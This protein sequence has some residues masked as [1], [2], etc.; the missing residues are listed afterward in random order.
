MKNVLHTIKEF[1]ST[2]FGIA[3]LV[4]YYWL[5][6]LAGFIVFSIVMWRGW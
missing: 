4:L 6:L 5:W 2:V 1:W 3:L